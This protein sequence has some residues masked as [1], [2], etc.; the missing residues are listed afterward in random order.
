M[1]TI[2]A[3]DLIE[4]TETAFGR[5][6]DVLANNEDEV[7]CNIA[8]NTADEEGDQYLFSPLDEVE[9]A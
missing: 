6:L 8:T 9:L 5:V 4:G 3:K 2:L 7:V 1:D